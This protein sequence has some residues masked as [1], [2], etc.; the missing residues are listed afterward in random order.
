MHIK[1]VAGRA[2]AARVGLLVLP[3][4]RSDDRNH[5]L[6]EVDR[7]LGG[8]LLREARQ[9]G[10]HGNA[11]ER[12]LFQ[13]HGK[14]P[15]ANVLLFGCGSGAPSPQRA[16]QLADAVVQTARE[17]RSAAAHVSVPPAFFNARTAFH[18]AEGVRLAA[19]R[20][21]RYRSEPRRDTLRTVHLGVPERSAALDDGLR[22]A[23]AFA[24]A[25]ILARD[26]VNTP[27]ADLPPPALADA[28]SRLDGI[29][30]KV[31]DRA[32]IQALGMG[33]L[34]AVA[35]GSQHE[36]R[37]VE[38]T[39]RPAKKPTRTVAL[40]GKG[41]TFDSGGLNLKTAEGMRAQKRD[42][43]GAALV[44]G[45][46]SALPRLKPGV[47]VRGYVPSAENMPSGTAV[48]PGDVV[49]AYNG[50]TIEILNTDAEGRLILADAL[51]YAAAKK[52]DVILDFA[53]LTAA[54]HTALGSRCAAIM[55][56]D[57]KLVAAII[58]AG[59]ACAER[60]WELP[61]IEEYRRDIDSQIADVKNMG[62]GQAG[63]II[64][65]LFLREF[66]GGRRWAHV[67]FSS[68]AFSTGYACHPQGASG[69]GVRSVLHYLTRP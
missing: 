24:A 33:A 2:V 17:T 9:Q 48:R 53:T 57:R 32:A 19:Y 60:F 66:A 51:G 65:G 35:Q 28:A 64:G 62:E 7:K 61:L 67:D 43:A 58:E 34:L 63:T 31:H 30:V 44:I 25:T 10:F 12:F 13:T 42:M 40:V 55:G 15:A 27:A 49:R 8:P 5:E 26:L 1:F 14:L 38:M 54:V 3:V 11:D 21:E 59:T 4:F 29:E 36:P 52:P 22:R 16:Y 47:E 37:F 18:I 56:T 41:I 39:Y 6:A 23:E 45:V 20:F 68:T 46:M 69:F 50:K